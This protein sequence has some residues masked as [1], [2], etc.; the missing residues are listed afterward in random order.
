MDEIRRFLDANNCVPRARDAGRQHEELLAYVKKLEKILDNFD[1]YSP[2]SEV[3][4]PSRP[5]WL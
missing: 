2:G 5:R 3:D 1:T 4:F